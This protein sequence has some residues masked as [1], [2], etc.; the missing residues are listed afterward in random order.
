MLTDV[1]IWAEEAHYAKLSVENQRCARYEIFFPRGIHSM[2][3]GSPSFLQN[4]LS[5][6]TAW[7]ANS[8][9]EG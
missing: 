1:Y 5:I 7:P 2:K 3:L 8:A 4:V 6:E 9:I